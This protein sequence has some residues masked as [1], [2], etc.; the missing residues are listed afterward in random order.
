MPDRVAVKARPSVAARLTALV[1]ERRPF[2]AAAVERALGALA[3]S[4]LA[5]IAAID[6]VRAALPP[7]LRRALP[8]PPRELPETTP[9]IGAAARWASA[10]DELIEA[11]D[12]FLW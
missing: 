6:R 3:V 7:L 2:A 11:C 1:L 12:G 8:E 5:D 10:V 9:S 4:D